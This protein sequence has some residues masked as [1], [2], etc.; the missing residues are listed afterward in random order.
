MKFM[1]RQNNTKF[2]L[3]NRNSWTTDRCAA[4]HFPS[5]KAA[6]DAA[7]TSGLH[8]LEVVIHSDVVAFETSLPVFEEKIVSLR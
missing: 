2:L 5:M 7:V 1:L 3:A 4:E 6:I 8:D